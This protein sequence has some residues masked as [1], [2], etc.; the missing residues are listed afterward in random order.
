MKLNQC[1]NW[2]PPAEWQKFLT[3]DVHTCGEPLRIVIGGFPALSGPTILAQRSDVTARLDHLRTALMWEPRGHSDMYGCLIVAPE[4]PDADFG[5]LF[6]HNEGYSSMCGHG[7]IAVTTAL[8]ETGAIP[9]S[10]PDCELKIDSPAGR[11][12]AH[13]EIR[14]GKVAGVSFQ[15]VPSFVVELDAV[16]D[17]PGIGSVVYDLAYGGAFYAYVRGDQFDPPLQCLASDFA[18]MIELGKQ[19]KQEIIGSRNIHHPVHEE[20]G[21]LYGV[22]FVAPAQDPAHHSRNCCVF[23]EGEVDRSPTGTGVSGRAAIH[24]A[25]GEL[26]LNEKIRIESLL[27]TWM[28]VEIARETALGPYPAIVPH[29]SGTAFLTGRSEFWIDPADPLAYG[30]LLR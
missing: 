11:I 12:T 23:A 10:G 3:L 15:N 19:I 28:D 24:F 16:V 4:S 22:I 29:V 9:A 1:L 13:A 2:Q 30:F 25:R 5:I 18:R 14:N 7:I 20:L 26:K 8:L 6:T 27:G 17:I 21:F